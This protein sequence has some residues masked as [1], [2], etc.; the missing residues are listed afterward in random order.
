MFIQKIQESESLQRRN[1]FR[2]ACD[3]P[4]SFMLLK[5]NESGCPVSNE[6]HDGIICNLSGGGVKMI[7]DLEMEEE[8]RLLISLPLD[9]DDLFLPGEIRA[10]YN[11][12]NA[13]HPFQYGIMFSDISL[14]N[15]D[16]IARYLFR[17]QMQ[18]LVRP[19]RLERATY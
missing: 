14:T 19:A 18:H 2:M 16:R 8:D 10:K 12:N 4:T 15:Q 11:N 9:G 3:V 5:K 7:T 17:E 6:F 1:F 13:I